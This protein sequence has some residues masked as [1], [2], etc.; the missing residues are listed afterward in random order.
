LNVPIS[1]RLKTVASFVPIESVIADIGS[2]HAYLPVYLIENGRAKRAIAGEVHEGPFRSAERTVEE[3]NLT[4]RIE[5]RKGNGFEVIHEDDAVDT[6][7]IAG[8]GGGTI[9]EILERGQPLWKGLRRLVLQ[10]MNHAD[11]LRKYLDQHGWE[12]IDETLVEEDGILYEIIVCEKGR[13]GVLSE[14][15]Y[16]V[17]PVLLSSRHPLLW[18]K[19]KEAIASVERALRGMEKSQSI[20]PERMDAFRRLKKN[21]QEVLDLYDTRI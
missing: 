11:R 15:Q 21:W 9:Q 7:T 12:I 5:V 10:P 13:V 19:A 1:N 4:D 20:D 14:W 2:D 6:V 3:Y 17:G 8:M 16:T 18:K